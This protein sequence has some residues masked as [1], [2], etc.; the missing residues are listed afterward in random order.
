MG[1]LRRK[2]MTYMCPNLHRNR[3][4][5]CDECEKRKGINSHGS[6]PPCK[7]LGKAGERSG[8]S[9]ADRGYDRR[10]AEFSKEYLRRHPVCAMCGAPAE[11][12]DHI[13]PADVWM[14][15][16]GGFDYDE[17][18]YQPLCRKCNSK[19]GRTADREVRRKYLEDKGKLQGR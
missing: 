16:Q 13:I 10:W 4:G 11:V 8:T 7:P 3:S 15:A 18:N 1:T 9:S 6:A 19:K 5:Y 2:C 17:S 14:D 12:T